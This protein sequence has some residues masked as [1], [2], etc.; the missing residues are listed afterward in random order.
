MTR[1]RGRDVLQ[2]TFYARGKAQPKGSWKPINGKTRAGRNVTRLIPDNP[3]SEHFGHLVK[4]FAR[5][6]M[7]GRPPIPAGIPVEVSIEFFV[8][9]PDNHFRILAGIPDRESGSAGLRKAAPHSA[10]GKPD[11]DKLIRNVLDSLTG[12]VF[13]DD[14]QVVRVVAEKRFD[15]NAEGAMINVKEIQI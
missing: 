5:E 13:H 3:R 6:G 9:R 15:N 14:A 8:R 10:T 4:V 1:E 7:R 11:I 12:V 2:V